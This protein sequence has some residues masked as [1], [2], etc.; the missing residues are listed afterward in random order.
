MAWQWTPYTTVLVLAATISGTSALYVWLRDRV[1]GSRMAMVVAMA[2][3]AWMLGYVLELVIVDQSAKVFLNKVQYLGIVVVPGAWLAFTLQYTGRGGWLTS[4]HLALLC[5]EPVGTLA[6]VFT[7]ES[8][9]LFWGPASLVTDGS[10]SVLVRPHGM[11]YWVHAAYTYTL[12]LIALYLLVQMLVRSRHLYRRQASVLLLATLL[13]LLA[14][15]LMVSGLDIL[16]HLDLTPLA[17]TGSSLML[18]WSLFYLRI[19]DIVPVARRLVVE[20]MSDGVIVLDEQNRVVDLNAVVKS[21][22]GNGASDVIGQPVEQ[23]WPECLDLI[24]RY[25]D[26]S[27]IN[28]EIALGEGDVQRTYDVRISPILDWRNRLNSRVVVLRDITDRKHSREVLS[29]Y[30]ERLRILHAIDGAILAARSPRE[31]GLAALH[32]ILHLISCRRASI[33]LF[34]AGGE[35]VTLLSVQADSKGES[36]KETLFSL[37]EKES[38][39]A[40]GRDENPV[41]RDDLNPYIPPSVIQALEAEGLCAHIHTPLVCQGRLIGCFSLGAQSRDAFIPQHEDIAREVADHLSVALHQAR[42]RAALEA[43]RRRLDAL[44]EHLPEGILLLDAER[45]ILLAN[46]A[47]RTILPLLTDVSSGDVLTQLAGQPVDGLL[48]SP[49]EGRWHELKVDELPARVFEVVSQPLAGEAELGLWVLLI[50]D[51]TEEREFQQRAE[52]QERLAVVG[53]LAAGIAHDFNNIIATIILYTQL[54]LRSQDLSPKS[55]DRLKTISQQ[56]ARATD[57]IEQI[58]D[59]SRR[60]RLERQPLDLLPLFKELARMLGR[61]LGEDVRVELDYELGRYVVSADPT[62][63]QQAIMNLA[64]NARDAMPEGGELRIGLGQIEVRPGDAP[65]LPEMKVGEWVG[66]TVSDTGTGI[67]PYVLPHIYEPFFTTKPLGCGSGLGLS[68][69]YGIVAQ[70]EGYVDVKTQ[71]GYGTTFIIYLPALSMPEGKLLAPEVAALVLGQGETILVVED[72]QATRAALRETLEMLNYRVLVA[73]SGREAMTVFGQHADGLALV[74]SDLVMPGMG[75]E[76]LV[77]E[78]RKAD[79][80]LKALGIT[81]YALVEDVQELRDEGILEI[82]HKPFEVI[83]LA[84]AVRRALDAG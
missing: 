53:Q 81:G 61:T 84:E 29:Q 71:V 2:D 76:E 51:L 66:V 28:E 15:V 25:C 14:S 59:F 63:M 34:D 69:V 17:F 33:A 6:L 7:N 80:H 23:V 24:E 3:V 16:P 44:V 70:H 42:L 32:H 55:C 4:H 8:H 64:L 82:V 10:F 45:R 21:M 50:R 68:Q 41:V 38:L 22:F 35:D 67:P 83:T 72:D 27:G 48:L 74:V 47:A 62:R 46:P 79:P 30:A 57:L 40:F 56:A 12:L 77:R 54:L 11:A 1:P 73:S 49:S 26:G 19:S 52:Q 58:L 65:P 60:S 18:T 31:I 36:V 9:N 37:G 13:P 5:V 75:G 78:L 43:G 20:S 39:D